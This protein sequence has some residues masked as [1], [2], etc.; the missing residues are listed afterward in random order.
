MALISL[1]KRKKNIG[2]AL[3][4]LGPLKP[5]EPVIKPIERHVDDLETSL[6]LPS[7]PE[8]MSKPPSM[9]TF[10]EIPKEEAKP[11]TKK[12]EIEEIPFL[13]VPQEIPELEELPPEA[14]VAIKEAPSEVIPEIEIFE[15]KEKSGYINIEKYKIV[16]ETL[17]TMRSNLLKYSE[18]PT[19][20]V[21]IKTSKDL[22]YEKFRNVLEDIER[23]LLYIDKNVFGGLK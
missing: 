5:L 11:E 18:L 9:P 1:I 6:P 7:I 12:P 2:N 20:M 21:D 23:K 22:A 15:A 17:N 4:T 19:K 14:K 8:E 10:P 16:I 13:E 3:P